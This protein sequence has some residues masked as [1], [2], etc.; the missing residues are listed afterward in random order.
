[1]QE[2]DTQVEETEDSSPA[3]EQE[4]ELTIPKHR[5]DGVIEKV[6][7][8]TE[9]LALKDRA[10][11]EVLQARQPQG[12]PA[13]EDEEAELE[14]LGLSKEI[15]KKLDKLFTKKLDQA[16]RQ[17]GGHLS[18]IAMNVDETKFLQR[19]GLDKEVYL[20]KIREKRREAAARNSF[21]SIDD[22]Y[23]LIRFAEEEHKP[24]KTKKVLK[25]EEAKP[26]ETKVVEQKAVDKKV[27]PAGKS[28]EDWENEL[29]EQ[30]KASERGRI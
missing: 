24:L 7:R 28:I 23:G 3:E 27:T 1:M 13:A 6:K 22:A 20:E 11:S 29:D 14:S 15:T 8:L 16:V 19:K 12:Q 2:A 18:T 10:L 9:E 17:V 21:L 26:V 5:F 30:I 4:Q 25:A